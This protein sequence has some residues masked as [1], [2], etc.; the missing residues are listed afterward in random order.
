MKYK[1]KRTR[2][3]MVKDNV[4]QIKFSEKLI[5]LR[6]QF[7]EYAKAELP[8]YSARKLTILLNEII[9]EATVDSAKQ[10]F[11]VGYDEALNDTWRVEQ[12]ND[13]VRTDSQ[14]FSNLKEKITL[15]VFD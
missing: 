15:T 9:D 4:V 5:E 8:L 13:Y 10:G 6:K 3:V 14:T 7:Y 1:K 11:E 2:K 12:I